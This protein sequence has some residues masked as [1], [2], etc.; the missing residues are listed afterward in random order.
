MKVYAGP[1]PR[2]C[3]SVL[4]ALLFSFLS[5]AHHVQE[6]SLLLVSRVSL[7]CHLFLSG[8][9]AV[10]SSLLPLFCLERPFFVGRELLKWLF[11]SIPPLGEARGAVP[12]CQSLRLPHGPA[13][14]LFY[15]GYLW[16]Q[17]P[18]GG[19]SHPHPSR[20]MEK[21][22]H[23]HARGTS[24]LPLTLHQA[25]IWLSPFLLGGSRDQ[26]ILGGLGAAA[27]LLS[28]RGLAPSCGSTQSEP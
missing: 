6:I 22:W 9:V 23:T 4:T 16:G 17:S 11:S 27:E 12:L 7:L 5:P 1:C 20:P 19:S 10:E 14:A 24:R 2:S 18:A 13:P 21:P 28:C 26:P 8:G 15:Q 25:P 3:L